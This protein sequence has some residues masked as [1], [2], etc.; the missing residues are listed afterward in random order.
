MD[1]ET[2]NNAVSWRS[3]VLVVL[4]GA[5]GGG[6]LPSRLEYGLRLLLSLLLMAASVSLAACC[7]VSLAHALFKGHGR[8]PEDRDGD[9]ASF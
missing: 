8:G 1:W 2:V 7:I 3:V 4:L 9:A 5:V 6:L